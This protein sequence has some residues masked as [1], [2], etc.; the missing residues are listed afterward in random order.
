MHTAVLPED[1]DERE[2]MIEN[3]DESTKTELDEIN[4]WASGVC[5]YACMYI[6]T[7]KRS[8][9]KKENKDNERWC[10]P[11]MYDENA[12]MYYARNRG[13]GRSGQVRDT[14][15]GQR[16]WDMHIR[17]GKMY[18]PMDRDARVS[19]KREKTKGRE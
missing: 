14:E 6:M 2:A 15:R 9:E 3:G 10:D 19:T 8:V 16:E 4:E 1:V 12:D 13:D 17:K 7:K 11:G 18:G 5:M